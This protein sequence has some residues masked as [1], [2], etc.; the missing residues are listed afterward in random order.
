LQGYWSIYVRGLGKIFC[1]NKVMVSGLGLGW[2]KVKSWLSHA[3]GRQCVLPSLSHIVIPVDRWPLRWWCPQSP[4]PPPVDPNDPCR[5]AVPDSD[6]TPSSSSS[7][8]SFPEFLKDNDGA[9]R[10]GTPPIIISALGASSTT[11]SQ[12]SWWPRWLRRHSGW[13]SQKL[14]FCHPRI[15]RHKA[16]H[17]TNITTHCPAAS[18]QTPWTAA[19]CCR[20][21]M[22]WL[23]R[24]RATKAAVGRSL[25]YSF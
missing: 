10:K 21:K 9:G 22:H 7:S 3:D 13:C 20:I 17:P 6:T 11:W 4:P 16:A 18:R 8:S 19:L 14:R 12:W 25:P 2:V 5:A 1:S 24:G 15:V 23:C